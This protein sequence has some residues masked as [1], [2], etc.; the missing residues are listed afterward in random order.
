MDVE[1]L[2]VEMSVRSLPSSVLVVLV[3]SSV[4]VKVTLCKK[5]LNSRKHIYIICLK[6]KFL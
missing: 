1:K 2:G 5:F 4:T 3:F 6:L